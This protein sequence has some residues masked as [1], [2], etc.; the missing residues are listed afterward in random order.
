MEAQITR[1]SKGG[2]SDDLV[3]QVRPHDCEQIESWLVVRIADM[4]GIRADQI[5]LCEPFA[6]YGLSSV[7]AISL[8]GD[9]EEWLGRELP[10]TLAWDYPNIQTLARHLCE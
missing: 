7:D 10:A 2:S 1:T 9:L 5:D 6:T 8:T 4:L 3:S